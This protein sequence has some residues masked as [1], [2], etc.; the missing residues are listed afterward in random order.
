MNDFLGVEGR[1]IPDAASTP[2]RNKVVWDLG[3]SKITYEQHPYD[4][5]APEFHTDP[6]WHLDT[7][8]VDHARY[9]P[10]DPIPGY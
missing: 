7:P 5:G 2:G 1:A 3:G 10:G 4:L 8:G 9:L 6:H